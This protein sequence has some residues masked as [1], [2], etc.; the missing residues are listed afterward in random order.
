[1]ERR[2]GILV[3]FSGLLLGAGPRAEFVLANI[4]EESLALTAWVPLGEPH[5]I[6]VSVG[7]T[8]YYQNKGDDRERLGGYWASLFYGRLRPVAGEVALRQAFALGFHE[9]DEL[10]FL[11]LDVQVGFEAPW[12]AGSSLKSG[13]GAGYRKNFGRFQTTR[14]VGSIDVPFALIYPYLNLVSWEF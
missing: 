6:G 4:P 10:K 13:A 3:L 8:E 7:E 11:F 9:Y 2:L 14:H 1:M 5:Y 12:G